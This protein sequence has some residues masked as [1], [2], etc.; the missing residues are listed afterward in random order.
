VLQD[1]QSRDPKPGP[2]LYAVRALALA[3][4]ETKKQLTSWKRIFE[5]AAVGRFEPP[6]KYT[7][8]NY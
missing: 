1:R 4:A 2:G 7:A 6:E 8:K 3:L 5:K